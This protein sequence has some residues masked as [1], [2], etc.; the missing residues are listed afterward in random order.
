MSTRRRA[1]W[2]NAIAMTLVIS[3]CSATSPAKP[4]SAPR[5]L[6]RA[7]SG[8]VATGGMVDTFPQPDSIFTLGSAPGAGAWRAVEGIWGVDHHQ[9]YV[10]G[11]AQGV[12]D[13]AVLDMGDGG[14]TMEVGMARATQGAGIVFRYL[15][16][17][18]YWAVVDVPSYAT[19][20]VF[21][22]VHGHKISD[23]GTGISPVADGTRIGV[24]LQGSRVE[25]LFGSRVWKTFV[26]TTLEGAPGVGIIAEGSTA[27]AARFTD[28]EYSRPTG[29]GSSRYA[30][31]ASGG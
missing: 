20:A 10:A 2:A 19:W 15:D 22:V 5:S 14:H 16:R 31:A 30:P 3:G 8:L 17:E 26:D 25:I 29:P 7:T 27:N 13:L 12:P 11:P 24:R 23:G 21:K 28:F 18:D 6:V 1:K 9:G 4:A